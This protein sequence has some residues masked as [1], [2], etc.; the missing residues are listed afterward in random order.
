[1]RHTF[2]FPPNS[3]DF[4]GEFTTSYKELCRGQSQLN[5]HEVSADKRLQPV[6]VLSRRRRPLCYTL[7]AAAHFIQLKSRSQVTMQTC[8]IYIH[9]WRT[10][11]FRRTV[12]VRSLSLSQQIKRTMTAKGCVLTITSRTVGAFIIQLSTKQTQ[13]QSQGASLRNQLQFRNKS[14]RPL[15]QRGL[16]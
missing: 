6:T 10:W 2:Y 15:A 7:N 11:A 4:I 16:V 13:A 1:M 14:V 3:H 12:L 8:P 5:M 9:L